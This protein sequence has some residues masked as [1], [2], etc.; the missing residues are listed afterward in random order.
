MQIA[1]V[2][3]IGEVSSS[4]I[5]KDT[6]AGTPVCI[7]F[8]KEGSKFIRAAVWGKQAF[9]CRMMLQKNS[10]V[11]LEGT[12]EIYEGRRTLLVAH[13]NKLTAEGKLCPI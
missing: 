5:L 11:Y 7:F 12:I 13:L 6:E 10:R 4:P 2:V 3:T 8:I 1:P 9:V